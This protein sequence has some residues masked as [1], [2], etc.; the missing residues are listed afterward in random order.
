MSPKKKSMTAI[1]GRLA[2]HCEDVTVDKSA[3]PPKT[4]RK[5]PYCPEQGRLKRTRKTW[6]EAISPSATLRAK[7]GREGNATRCLAHSADSGV[8]PDSRPASRHCTER[9]RHNASLV[10]STS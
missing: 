7:D 9:R 2:P 3:L 1:L 6:T 5:R 10:L 4:E 8:T